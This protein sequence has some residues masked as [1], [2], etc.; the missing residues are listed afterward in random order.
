MNIDNAPSS[1]VL[2]VV[3]FDRELTVEELD[4]IVPVMA[5]RMKEQRIPENLPVPDANPVRIYGGAMVPVNP[6]DFA[7]PPEPPPLRPE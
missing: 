5:A 6:S 1:Q 7:G 3:E 4:A 2:L